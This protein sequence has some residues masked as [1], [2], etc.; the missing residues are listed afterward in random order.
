M[1]SAVRPT[2]GPIAG[3]VVI[4]HINKTKDL[5]EF[6]DNGGLIARRI[7]ELPDRDEDMAAML[8][9]SMIV[10]QDETV[11][12]G[13]A[14]AAVLLEAIF[15][16]GLRYIAAGGNA[17]QLRRYLEGAVPL[18]VDALDEMIVPLDEQ[19]ALTNMAYTLCHDPEMAGLLGEAQTSTIVDI[20]VNL[21]I[22]QLSY[23]AGLLIR[24]A[25]RS[26]RGRHR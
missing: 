8:V 19:H 5:P 4:D 16:G 10:R 15:N 18:I 26:A 24:T 22:L 7:I 14:T 6:L 20:V 1:V 9:R 2:L 23:L 12:D 3:G 25:V 21:V 11:G 17:M 13:T